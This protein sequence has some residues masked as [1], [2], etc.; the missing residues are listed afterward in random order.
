NAAP[1][2]YLGSIAVNAAP[3]ARLELGLVVVAPARV[4][5]RHIPGLLRFVLTGRSRPAALLALHDAD[6]V[7]VHCVIELPLQADGEDLGDVAEAVFEA[8]RGALTVLV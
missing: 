7:P 6:H 8:E 2:T 3:E 4:R 5:P 1:Y